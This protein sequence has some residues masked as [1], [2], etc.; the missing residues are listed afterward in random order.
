MS[1]ANVWVR[2]LALIVDVIVLY[3]PNS[4]MNAIVITVMGVGPAL[5][6]LEAMSA[7]SDGSSEAEIAQVLEAISVV[8]PAFFVIIVLSI[9]ISWLYNALMESSSTQATLGKM[10]VGIHV[11]D[12]NGRRISFLRATGRYFAKG[13]LSSILLIGYIMAFFTNRKQALHDLMAGT[14]VLKKKKAQSV[15]SSF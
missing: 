10:A 11:T 8:L 14:L 13:F 2:L 12:T 3:I 6:S 9:I 1:Y 15:D 7:N 4:I 5:A